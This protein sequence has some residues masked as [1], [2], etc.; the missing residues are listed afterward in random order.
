VL[1][2]FLL[3]HNLKRIAGR[4]GLH[5]ITFSNKFECVAHRPTPQTGKLKKISNLR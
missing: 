5:F 2:L 1:F 3:P 4:G